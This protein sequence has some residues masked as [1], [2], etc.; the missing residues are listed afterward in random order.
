MSESRGVEVHAYILG[1]NPGWIIRRHSQIGN[2]RVRSM[3]RT[4]SR[5]LVRVI[6]AGGADGVPFS[7]PITDGP[8]IQE[9]YARDTLGRSSNRVDYATI[10]RQVR[11]ARSK[12]LTVPVLLMGYYNPRLAYGEDQAV[13]DARE[14]GANGF[15]MVDPPPKRRWGS[16]RN[17]R[18]LGKHMALDVAS[19][20]GTIESSVKGFVNSELSGIIARSREHNPIPLVVGLGVATRLHFDT[21]VVGSRIVSLMPGRSCSASGREGL[22]ESSSSDSSTAGIQSSQ[23]H[24]PV[25]AGISRPT[26]MTSTTL[27][28]VRQPVDLENHYGYMN[29]PSKLYFAETLTKYANCAQLWLEREDPNHTGSHKIN[30]ADGQV[31]L[32]KCLGKTRIIAETGA[33]LHG[34]TTATI[35]ARIGMECIIYMGAEDA[36]RQA[37]NVFRMKMLGAKNVATEWMIARMPPSKLSSIARNEFTIHDTVRIETIFQGIMASPKLQFFK[38]GLTFTLVSLELLENVTL[39]AGHREAISAEYSTSPEEPD[40][41]G[42]KVRCG[43]AY[44]TKIIHSK[45][46]ASEPGQAVISY[47]I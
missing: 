7:D 20:M 14:A 42:S 12:G 47:L 8:V 24:Y 35:R 17:A 30:N 22:K 6:Q 4:N 45:V 23:Y 32:A 11:E 10:L 25:I 43:A 41:R 36:R 46:D 15:I 2:D 3:A 16:A 1:V 9:T 29:H 34:V 37:L 18:T 33:R 13:Q 19:R 21:V 26:G 27:W 39:E 38:M 40:S 31:S 44:P 5:R 28:P